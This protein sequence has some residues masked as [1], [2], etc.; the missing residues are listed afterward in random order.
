MQAILL[1]MKYI[2][3]ASNHSV[4]DPTVTADARHLASMAGGSILQCSPMRTWACG[5]HPSLGWRVGPKVQKM[6]LF[7]STGG[8]VNLWQMA[9]LT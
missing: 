5:R 9:G 6:L 8:G 4:L 3:Q 7:Y 2:Q 1:D